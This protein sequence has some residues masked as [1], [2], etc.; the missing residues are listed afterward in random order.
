M[1]LRKLEKLGSGE[2][3]IFIKNGMLW[4][5]VSATGRATEA[6]LI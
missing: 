2:N 5:Q 6:G 3:L 1:W 4:V